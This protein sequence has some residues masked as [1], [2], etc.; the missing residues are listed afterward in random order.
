MVSGM[1][2]LFNNNVGLFLI[3]LEILLRLVKCRKFFT[4]WAVVL[5]KNRLPAIDA[6][7]AVQL[8]VIQES[9]TTKF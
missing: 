7:H 8:F 6:F 9:V 5:L 1:T 3:S 2:F 4:G